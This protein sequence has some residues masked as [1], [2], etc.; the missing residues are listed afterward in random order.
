MKCCMPLR[1]Y[2]S[3]SWVCKVNKLLL[4]CLTFLAFSP[5]VVC[6]EL[7]YGELEKLSTT[8]EKLKGHFVQEKYISNLSISLKSSGNFSYQRGEAL[9][10][11]TMEPIQHKLIMTRESIIN[12]QGENE[13]VHLN[14]NTNPAIQVISELFFSV[15]TA[16]WQGLERFFKLSSGKNVNGQW[17]AELL[18][19]DNVITQFTDRVTLQGDALLREVTIYEKNGDYTKI[20][21][22][23]LS[24]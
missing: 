6:A 4:A 5:I 2:F 11:Q 8:P 7:S 15:L 12:K 21:F 1:V 24:Q 3:K 19:I 14:V 17:A 16:E 10:W 13:L 9:Q 18:P 22:D 23:N 20:Q